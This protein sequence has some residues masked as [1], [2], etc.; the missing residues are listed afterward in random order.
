MKKFIIGMAIAVAVVFTT[1][2]PASAENTKARLVI[3]I[4]PLG[5]HSWILKGIKDGAFA[6][7]GVDVEFIGKGP[8]SVKTA[9]ALSAGKA[10]LGY[11]DYSGLVLVNSK[12]ADPKVTAIFVVDDKAQDAV[13][14]L[15]EK[16]ITSFDKLDGK[17][18]GGFITGVT[19][20]VLPAVTTA[21]WEMVNMP[22]SA[23]VPSLTTGKVDAVEGFITTNVFNFEKV[24][25]TRDKLNIIRMSDK[26]PTAVSRVITVNSDWAAA[27]P[28][29]V[30]AIR[31]VLRELVAGFVKNP[32]ASVATL[33]GP[34]VSTDAKRALELRRAQYGINELVN[35][36][37]V[38]KNGISNAKAVGPRLSEYTSLLVTKLDLPNRHS[39]SKYFD[40]D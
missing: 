27:N 4:G 13:F 19:N 16:G 20:K 38:Q 2:I 18:L 11:H 24:G 17:T 33:S 31:E 14:S 7:R 3:D 9:L 21:K 40:L 37:F 23:R 26:F 8:G 6:R 22:F 15:K 30:V 34:I 12:S 29:A 39:D 5:V 1:I 32:A 25:V 28:K 10:E 36:P 35:T